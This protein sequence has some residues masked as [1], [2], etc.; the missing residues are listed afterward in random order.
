LNREEKT[1]DSILAGLFITTLKIEE[2]VIADQ[3]D[4]LLSISE[5]HVLREIGID[6]TRTMTQVAKG[7]KISVG[8]LTTAMTKLEK[9]GYVTR[10]RDMDD[11]RIVNLRLTDVG[12]EK[13]IIHDEF[14]RGM[15][16]AAI[17]T[18]TPEEKRVFL[19]ALSKLDDWF[20]D[21]WNKIRER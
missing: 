19:K 2:K 5:L 4:H 10:T 15:V 11:K 16:N 18:L 13:F 20:V 14:H 3:S 9:K 7:L 8:A 17:S 12:R 21:E 1:I 6:G